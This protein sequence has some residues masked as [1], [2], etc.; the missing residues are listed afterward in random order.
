MVT[1]VEQILA[2]EDSAKWDI[3][4]AHNIREL[5]ANADFKGFMQRTDKEPLIVAGDFNC[6][7]HLDWTEETK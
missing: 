3:G 1:K 5:L 6:P 7:S 4:R 2:G